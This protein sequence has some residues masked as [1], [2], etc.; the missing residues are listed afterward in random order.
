V[1]ERRS[2]LHQQRASGTGLLSYS[3]VD[4]ATADGYVTD[5]TIDLMP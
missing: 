2:P 4:V 1:S 3:S 5:L